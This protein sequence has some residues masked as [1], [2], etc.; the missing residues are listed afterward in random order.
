[1]AV[2]VAR[3]VFV[4]QPFLELAV[5]ADYVRRDPGAKPVEFGGER[6]IGA[7]DTGGLAAGL[8]QVG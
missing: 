1:M 2:G 8:E 5:L 3:V 6:G 7:E 4:F